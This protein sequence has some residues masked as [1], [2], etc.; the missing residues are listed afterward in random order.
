MNQFTIPNIPTSPDVDTLRLS[1]TNALSKL[2]GQLNAMP[3]QLDAAGQRVINVAWPTG[4]NDAVPL[5]YLKYFPNNGTMIS[6]QGGNGVDAY[7]IVYSGWGAWSTVGIEA[8]IV[9]RDREGY[10][11]EAWVYA[12]TPPVGVPF[13][14]N[15]SKNGTNIMSTNMSLG[16]GTNGPVFNTTFTGASFAHGDIVKL[17]PVSGGANALSVGLVVKRT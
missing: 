10:A 5:R 3:T 14:F 8:F 17:V 1:V 11:E 6:N 2:V 12:N 16:V 13:V 15:I 9:G 4:P 7:T